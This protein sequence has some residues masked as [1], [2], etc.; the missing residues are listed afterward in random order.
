MDDW[1]RWRSFLAVVDEGSLSAAARKLGLTQPTLGRHVDALEAS[2]GAVLF[3]RAQSGLVPTDLA[4][5]L[6]PEARSMALSA[7]TLHRR[8]SAPETAESGRVRLAASDVV[9]AEV[10]PP[11]LADFAVQFPRIGVDL[12][13]SNRNEDLLRHQ[14]DLA[15]RMVRPAQASLVGRRIG[16]VRLGLFAH[17][18]YV[19]RR[20]V[21]SSPEEL[22]AHLLIGPESEAPLAGVRIGG[23]AVTPSIF[24]Y[25]TDNDLGQLALLRAGLGIGICQDGIAERDDALLPVLRGTVAFRLE[26]WLAM[27]EDLRALRRVRLLYDFLAASLPVLWR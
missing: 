9:G 16:T 11:V 18:D 24:A 10:L 27:H 3:L 2:V 23:R 1:D 22:G 13:L 8:A 19:A 6:V 25:R 12:V 21:P 15:V 26:P 17:R 14:A 4:R 7:A 20:G 5:A